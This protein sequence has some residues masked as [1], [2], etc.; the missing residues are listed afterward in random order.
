MFFFGTKQG[1]KPQWSVNHEHARDQTL[2]KWV[3]SRMPNHWAVPKFSAIIHVTNKPQSA[4]YNGCK[5]VFWWK[6]AI[7]L[8][9]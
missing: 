9:F 2:G 5:Y 3:E 8:L 4:C 1:T 7:S 6:D